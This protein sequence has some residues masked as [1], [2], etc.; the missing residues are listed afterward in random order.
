L[1]D[2]CRASDAAGSDRGRRG[3]PG[4]G[5][6]RLSSLAQDPP[7][8]RT[9]LRLRDPGEGIATSLPGRP[10][11]LVIALLGGAQGVLGICRHRASLLASAR[12]AALKTMNVR[13]V[14]I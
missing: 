1:L 14:W 3:E 12:F 5:D 8:T 2:L 9:T 7:R 11:F 6:L 13:A 10:G 4:G